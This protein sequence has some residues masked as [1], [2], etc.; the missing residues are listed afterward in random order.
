M[1]SMLKVARRCFCCTSVRFSLNGV[2][3]RSL[4]VATPKVKSQRSPY[5]LA[6]IGVAVS[7]PLLWYQTLSTPDKRFVRTSLG[8]LV[9]FAKTLKIGLTI[10][11]DYSYS[12]K[13]YT[14]GTEDY[15]AMMKRCHQRSAERILKGCLENGGL[16]I[17]LGQSL[18]AL[19]HL[20]PREYLDTLE[21]LHDHALVRS[22][23]EISELFRED[24]GCLPEEMFKEFNRTPIAA[25]SLAQ[26]FKAKTTEGKDV[27]VKVQYIDL[28]QRFSGDLHGIGILVNIVSWM[29]P[30]FNFA[31]I[32]DY[33]RSCLVK[34]L[35]FVHE[36][37]NM[38]RC[39]RDLA[40]LPY[41][42]VPGV[43]WS[44]TSKRVLT[45][46]FVN[47]VKISDVKGIKK[48]GLDLADVDRKMVAAFAE[49]IFHTGFVHAD[50]HPGNVFVEKGKDGKARIVLLDHGLYECISKEN[51]LSLCQLWKSIIMNDR[52]GMKTH[53][54]ELGVA[55]Y[56]IFCE[57]L[58]QRPLQ[59]QTFRLRNQL[60]SEDV[61]YMRTMV[62]NHFDEVM[63]CI[64]S[65]PR[66]MLLIFRNINT[67]RSITKN[68]GHPVDRFTLMARIATRRLTLNLEHANLLII[69]HH[70]WNCMVF[71]FR[72]RLEY[73]QL[74]FSL[75]YLRLLLW[76]KGPCKDIDYMMEL[77][78]GDVSP[79]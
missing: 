2:G 76:I 14:E 62:Q 22:K 45:M 36:A 65:L 60:S 29:H 11:C 8:G 67:V 28:Q 59:R 58:M 26:V 51:R 34:E 6:F 39:A 16:Y 33:L 73:W 72:L 18:V 17:K 57:I 21:V 77:A 68:H 71:E 63:D 49:Q 15:K 35:D 78:A 3:A 40:H 23:D 56:P 66:P 47:G 70:W 55:N 38:E 13:G 44:K 50:P 52:I 4:K 74:K 12:A 69:L 43:H 10:S 53:S 79:L 37:G 5:V 32:L 20:L 24:F 61:A 54:L 46:D 30:D 1:I 9:R 75:L 64:R 7:A 31:W 41:V 27:A 19:N 48:L 42:S 25:A